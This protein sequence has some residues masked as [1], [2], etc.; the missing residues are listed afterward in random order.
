LRT[1]SRF[2]Q[3]GSNPGVPGIKSNTGDPS[4][5]RANLSALEMSI[6][7]IIHYT[8]Y[9]CSVYL[10]TYSRTTVWVINVLLSNGLAELRP[11]S[12]PAF[13]GSAPLHR[14]A[15]LCSSLLQAACVSCKNADS[16]DEPLRRDAMIATLLTLCG[17]LL[18]TVNGKSVG[19]SSS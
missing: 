8:I 3:S 5:T 15:D 6:A 2:F 13:L 12:G 14:S 18:A 9:K 1:G 11:D 19:S 7:H 4:L 17:F 10:V 16:A